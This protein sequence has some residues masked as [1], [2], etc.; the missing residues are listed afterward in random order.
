MTAKQVRILAG[1]ASALAAVVIGLAG[2][3]A[4]TSH[5]TAAARPRPASETAAAAR[6]T[7][8]TAA[9]PRTAVRLAAPLLKCADPVAAGRALPGASGVHAS[10]PAEVGPA[11]DASA[12]PVPV[13]TVGQA[14]LRQVGVVNLSHPFEV[15]CGPVTVRCPPGF[16]KLYRRTGLSGRR[17][18]VLIPEFAICVA[19][20]REFPPPPEPRLTPQP[21]RTLPP[22]TMPPQAAGQ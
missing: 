20:F 7:P 22:H 12:S 11:Q 8:L 17:A 9:R 1:S 4:A 19:R 2:C 5:S 21:L 3:A 15:L 13:A 16:R 14:T 18:R 10:G 6:A